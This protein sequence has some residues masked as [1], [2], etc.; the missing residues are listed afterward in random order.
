PAH[1]ARPVLM[2]AIPAMVSVRSGDELPALAIVIPNR[3][4]PD[5][6][7][8]CL[9]F[10]EF[11]NRFRPELVIVDNASEEAAVHA[12]YRDL[13]ARHGAR[14]VHMDQMFNFSRMINLGI[15]ATSSEAVLLLNNDVEITAP[16]AIEQMIAH[17][18]RPEV[19]VVGCRLLYADGAVQ[20][21]G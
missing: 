4:R 13:R 16:G 8:R 21:A 10:L 15:A 5:L 18:M 14:I 6:L 11:P 19:G 2:P 3:N 9:R 1:A 17:A 20:H 7:T 12:I